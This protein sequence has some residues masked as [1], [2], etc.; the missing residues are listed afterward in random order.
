MKRWILFLVLVVAV[1]SLSCVRICD[2]KYCSTPALR[3]HIKKQRHH[4]S[5]EGPC[6]QSYGFPSSH[7]QMW[8]L[9]HKEC[10]VPMN[11]CFQTVVLEKKLE[12][13]L[14]SKEIKL[15]NLKGYQPWIFIGNTYEAEAPFFLPPDADL[16]KRS[17][18]WERLRAG[19]EGENR[20][21]D[22]WIISLTQL[23]WVWA[24]SGR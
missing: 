2:P 16:L 11:W 9:Y 21:F 17:L 24:N 1:Q 8:N 10:W 18:Y 22:H 4:F 20:G 15:V 13:P 5:D 12:S 3:H 19:G 23:T 6:C 7:E 14:D